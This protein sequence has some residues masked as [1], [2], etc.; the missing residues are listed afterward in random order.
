[1]N[2]FDDF[3]D[4]WMHYGIPILIIIV[5]RDGCKTSKE[6]LRAFFDAGKCGAEQ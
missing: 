5:I 6:M 4:V 3:L 2:D 1:M